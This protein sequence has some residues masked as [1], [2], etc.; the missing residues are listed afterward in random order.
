M[1]FRESDYAAIKKKA[2]A[3]RDMPNERRTESQGFNTVEAQAEMGSG[4]GDIAV[5][6]LYL[7]A[8]ITT[9][10]ET[11]D[12]NKQKSKIVRERKNGQKK[13]D[14]HDDGGMQMNM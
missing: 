13:K 2:T 11:N 5:N 3:Q 4:W 14:R 7:A 8:D 6:A 12:D 1:R 10:G 9:I